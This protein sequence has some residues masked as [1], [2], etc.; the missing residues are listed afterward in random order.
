MRLIDL[1]IRRNGSPCFLARLT[2]EWGRPLVAGWVSPDPREK[3]EAAA[4]L[5]LLCD[6]CREPVGPFT[7]QSTASDVICAGCIDRVR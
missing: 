7:G 2:A 5:A 3:D 6:V 1:L 4:E